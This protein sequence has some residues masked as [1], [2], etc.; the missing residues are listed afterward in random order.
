MSCQ[1]VSA[2]FQL[3]FFTLRQRKHDQIKVHKMFP[4]PSLRPI[5]I[6]GT[7]IVCLNTA[8]HTESNTKDTH[9]QQLRQQQAAKVGGTS[10]HRH[11]CS[12]GFPLHFFILLNFCVEHS[13]GRKSKEIPAG[14]A[15]VMQKCGLLEQRHMPRSPWKI[16]S[17]N[18]GRCPPPHARCHKLF[19]ECVSV[20]IPA[21]FP[22]GLR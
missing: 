4:K 13:G 21:A 12:D 17:I 10:V 1:L 3:P 16:K 6:S 15:A 19:L 11:I 8:E 7:Q 18:P 9:E 22:R 20:N 14:W 5:C 2:N